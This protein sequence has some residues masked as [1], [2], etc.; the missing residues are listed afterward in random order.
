MTTQS[1]ARGAQNPHTSLQIFK[2]EGSEITF[3][4]ADGSLMV[5]LT[6]MAKVF[7]KRPSHFLENEQTK[8]FIE[9]LNKSKVGIPTLLLKHGGSNRGTWGHEKL[10]LKFAAWLSP[11]FELWVYDRIH[12]IIKGSIQQ[13]PSINNELLE[14]ILNRMD[15]H[16]D[17]VKDILFVAN[18]FDKMFNAT[19]YA[20]WPEDSN[21]QRRLFMA[22]ENLTDAEVNLG[23]NI[24]QSDLP[25][26]AINLSDQQAGVYF[27]LLYSLLSLR[28]LNEVSIR[29]ILKG[30][31]HAFT[32]VKHLF[33]RDKQ[34]YYYLPFITS[35]RA[36]KHAYSESRKANRLKA[37]G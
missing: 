15:E 13:H 21:P 12:E 37:W 34:G 28:R 33:G 24:R 6:E 17:S 16:H 3:K 29:R 23:V 1:D 5:N 2:Y 36:R 14:R 26:M 35:D 32:Q 10:A 8:A 18:A 4:N 25:S 9:E 20:D 7:K 22:S 31:T 19:G 30:R 27:K 11:K